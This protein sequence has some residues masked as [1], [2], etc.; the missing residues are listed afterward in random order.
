MFN[1]VFAITLMIATAF[2]TPEQVRT[3]IAR[4]DSLR[5]MYYQ[6]LLAGEIELDIATK[7]ALNN[8]R[9]DIG[10]D[11]KTESYGRVYIRMGNVKGTGTD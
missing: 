1:L 8:I 6:Q 5:T 7:L 10:R 3:D 2:P 9:G 11:F 4:A